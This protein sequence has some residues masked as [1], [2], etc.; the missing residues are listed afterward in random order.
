MIVSFVTNIDAMYYQIVP[1][2]PQK[3]HITCDSVLLLVAWRDFV[4]EQI[5]HV[6]WTQ[7]KYTVEKTSNDD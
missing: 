5:N 6:I 7:I 1:K 4:S 3:K 2:K